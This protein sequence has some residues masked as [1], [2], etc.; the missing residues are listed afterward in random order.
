[1]LY[2]FSLF[3]W[4]KLIS[5]RRTFVSLNWKTSLWETTFQNVSYH[6]SS[7]L[8]AF[9]FFA[10]FHFHL[11]ASR[12]TASKIKTSI[13]WLRLAYILLLIFLSI[14]VRLSLGS[15]MLMRSRGMFSSIHFI[16]FCGLCTFVC[17]RKTYKHFTYKSPH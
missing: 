12:F 8:V 1:M 14:H 17:N 7:T 10:F 15:V 5:A 6:F 2:S 4:D 16:S 9:H 11:P 3:K 13:A